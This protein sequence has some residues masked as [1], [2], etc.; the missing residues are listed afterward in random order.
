MAAAEDP[1]FHSGD[2]LWRF[3]GAG[4][5]DGGAVIRQ[6]GSD[7]ERVDELVQVYAQER[8]GV[9][10]TVHES[11]HT[12]QELEDAQAAL[13]DLPDHQKA[14]LGMGLNEDRSDVRLVVELLYPTAE[15]LAKLEDLP[16]SIVQV[17]YLVRSLRE[18]SEPA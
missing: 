13:V 1:L 18:V 9:P 7:R 5:Q 10:V 8:L 11:R 14:S 12:W 2:V 4:P 3:L 16:E 17:N 15:I 6:R